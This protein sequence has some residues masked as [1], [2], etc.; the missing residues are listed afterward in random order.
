MV[1]FE[2][3]EEQ[4]KVSDEFIQKHVSCARKHP[5]A[6][7]GFITYHFTPTSVGT[8]CEIKCNVCNEK[9]DLTDYGIW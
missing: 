7:G 1:T 8:G 2:L 9:L 5:T 6:I 4:T 3:T